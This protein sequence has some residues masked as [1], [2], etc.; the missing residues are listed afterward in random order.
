MCPP[1][2]G[3]T[4]VPPTNRVF[5]DRN[6]LLQGDD[7][8]VPAVKVGPG[9]AMGQGPVGEAVV[10]KFHHRSDGRGQGLPGS[11]D[12]PRLPFQVQPHGVRILAGR[13][14]PGP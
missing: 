7:E 13:A 2:R 11:H 4:W 6:S 5:F 12:G 3:H 8:T 14:P 1:G 10:L 9:A